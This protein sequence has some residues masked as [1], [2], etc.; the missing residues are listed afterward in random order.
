MRRGSL[1]NPTLGQFIVILLILYLFPTILTIP[2]IV[3]GNKISAIKMPVYNWL[4][5]VIVILSAIWAAKL[6]YKEYRVTKAG[7]RE[8]DKMQG[9]EFEQKLAVLFEQMGY[10]V[11]HTGK[12]GDYGVDLI[13]EKYGV[14]TAVQAKRYGFREKVPE[15]AIQQVFTGAKYYNCQEALAVTNRYYTFAAYHLA[16]SIHVIIWTRKDLINALLS[17]NNRPQPAVTKTSA[18]LFES[19]PSQT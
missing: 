9:E 5:P 2:L 7:I 13:I 16:K 10:T 4:L 17:V 6:L 14:R 19:H 11:R 3:T 12:T 1:R 18:I 15:S 8:I